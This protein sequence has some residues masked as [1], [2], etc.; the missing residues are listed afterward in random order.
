M[1]LNYQSKKYCNFR[2]LTKNN[3]V[4][5]KDKIKSNSFLCGYLRS[6]C[7]S[8]AQ[9]LC[10]LIHI[11]ATICTYCIVSRHRRK[12][13]V[14]VDS[15]TDTITAPKHISILPLFVSVFLFFFMSNILLRGV[16]LLSHTMVNH[17]IHNKHRE[18]FRIQIKSRN[19][20]RVFNYETNENAIFS[21]WMAI[22][23]CILS[24]MTLIVV[25]AIHL[26]VRTNCP[27]N[28]IGKKNENLK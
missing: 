9:F 28:K 1:P 6:S 21:I 23:I 5:F 4:C 12:F 25:G 2:T 22:Y 14:K 10:C 24:L 20:I 8:F 11:N 13:P 15:N 18:I 7:V 3:S 27:T 19:I 16:S 26:P 17:Y